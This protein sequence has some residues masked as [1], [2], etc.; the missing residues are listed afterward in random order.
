MSTGRDAGRGNAIMQKRAVPQKETPISEARNRSDLAT[1]ATRYRSDHVDLLAIGG[2]GHHVV[3]WSA[4]TSE[5]WAALWF[6]SRNS[7]PWVCFTGWIY[8][9]L[10]PALLLCRMKKLIGK[11][12]AD[13]SAATAIE[14]GLIAAGIAL[15]I[16]AVVNGLGS[17]LNTK[18][19][20]I[21]S[22][23]K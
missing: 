19:T 14:Y 7:H 8:S 13:E 16:I 22:S 1:R 6:R 4:S 21:S 9:A 15:A 23:L 3:G 2:V 20:S 12:L 18:F 5:D 17:K 11:F 10:K